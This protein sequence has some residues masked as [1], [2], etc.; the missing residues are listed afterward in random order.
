MKRTLALLLMMAHIGLLTGAALSPRGGA[1]GDR[2]N[3]HDMSEP[4][5]QSTVGPV[6]DCGHCPM[7]EC[8]SMARCANTVTAM[9]ATA[10]VPFVEACSPAWEGKQPS[11]EITAAVPPILPPPRA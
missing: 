10:H 3:C 11:C 6:T 8:A 7:D 9:V 4:V 1:S 5:V 2:V